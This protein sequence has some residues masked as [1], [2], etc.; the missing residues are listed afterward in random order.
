[1]RHACLSPIGCKTQTGR[2][3]RNRNCTALPEKWKKFD[4]S[5]LC[6][7]NR[8]AW[9]EEPVC[10]T[11]ASQPVYSPAFR[12][13]YMQPAKAGTTYPPKEYENFILYN[14]SLRLAT[15][16]PTGRLGTRNRSARRPPAIPFVDPPSGGLSCNRL[17]PGLHTLRK[18]MKIPTGEQLGCRC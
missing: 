6:N 17:K 10:S 9:D 16:V 3:G 4:N 11:T 2:Y 14:P 8:E 15:C 12:R 1:M 5:L 13:H 7:P 18:S